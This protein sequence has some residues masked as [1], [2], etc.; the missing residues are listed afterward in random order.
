L[1]A[2]GAYHVTRRDG[3]AGQTIF[4]AA[5]F[6][7]VLLALYTAI[8]VVATKWAIESDEESRER[9]LSAS[10]PEKADLIAEFLTGWRSDKK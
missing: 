2:V 8:S 1:V 5:C 10:E 7:I 6:Y 4:V 9:F 3:E